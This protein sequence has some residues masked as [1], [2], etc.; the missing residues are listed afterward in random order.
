[1]STFEQGCEAVG[2]KQ[3]PFTTTPPPRICELCCAAPVEFVPIKY[4]EEHLIRFCRAC[5]KQHVEAVGPFDGDMAAVRR[6]AMKR[7]N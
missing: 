7:G 6:H 2:F 3:V 1:M 4:G 5:M